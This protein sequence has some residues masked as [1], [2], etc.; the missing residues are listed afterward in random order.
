MHAPEQ[1][2]E[3][4]PGTGRGQA[5]R[6]A[7][8]E[9]TEA[10]RRSG[11]AAGGHSEANSGAGHAV[12]E[13]VVPM[14]SRE[15]LGTTHLDLLLVQV[16]LAPRQPDPAWTQRVASGPDG[17]QRHVSA[18]WDLALEARGVQGALRISFPCP[19]VVTGGS[20]LPEG[21]ELVGMFAYRL[22]SGH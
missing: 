22:V 18:V 21:Q 3:A 13:V 5:P 15:D 6:E 1:E 8:S 4:A 10:S 19:I 20:H 17:R 14:P 2:S 9:R 12:R 16:T 11:R 7:G